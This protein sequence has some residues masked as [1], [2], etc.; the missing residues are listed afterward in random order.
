MLDLETLQI[1]FAI[2][3]LN[4]I[5]NAATSLFMP[6][7]TVSH[8]L[9]LLE[10]ELGVSLFSRGK[11]LKHTVL[12]KQGEE[13][14]PIATKLLTLYKEAALLKYSS[15]KTKLSISGVNSINQYVLPDFYKTFFM[16]NPDLQITLTN[17]NSDYIHSLLENR[18]IDIG[19][20]NTD[21]P[22][23][24]IESHLLFE[25]QFVVVIYYPGE[26]APYP[27]SYCIH[28]TE[29]NGN[30]EIFQDFDSLYSSWHA[31]WWSSEIPK[32]YVNEAALGRSFFHSPGDWCIIPHSIAH[33]FYNER[34]FH[35]YHLLEAPPRRVCYLLYH[36]HLH[37][38]NAAAI[39]NFR[40][41]LQEFIRAAYE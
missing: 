39:H 37:Y 20:S 12:T 36:K 15:S 5:S 34:D 17:H 9:A 38:H 2:K 18:T 3:N 33:A 41:C 11:G 23:S 1:F 26:E 4:S 27:E 10:A 28:P 14:V 19:I 24:D 31:Q 35:I 6:Q 32:V 16:E 25:E 40:L 22:F 13:F 21:T 29:L 8:K 30:N 7:P